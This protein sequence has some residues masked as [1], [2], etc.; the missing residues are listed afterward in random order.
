MSRTNIKIDR[1]RIRLK[2]I[3]PETAQAAVAGLGQ[4]LLERLATLPPTKRA[5]RLSEIDAGTLPAANTDRSADLRQTIA[6]KIAAA[7]A[8]KSGQSS[9]NPDASRS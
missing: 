9:I 6:G 1:L 5:R 3:S 7:I 4:E 2:G 8:A